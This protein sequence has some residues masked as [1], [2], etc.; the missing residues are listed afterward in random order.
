MN[1]FRWL[2]AGFTKVLLIFGVFWD[3][4]ENE[5]I[6][7]EQKDVHSIELVEMYLERNWSKLESTLDR[8]IQENIRILT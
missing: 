3:F 2:V 6:L 5:E 4:Q 1:A 7:S 8:I